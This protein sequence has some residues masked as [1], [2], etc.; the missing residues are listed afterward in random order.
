MQPQRLVSVVFSKDRPLQLDGTLRSLLAHV[1]E[2][3]HCIKVLYTTSSPEQTAL[4]AEVM[5]DFP[6]V[7]FVRESSFK[8]DLLNAL[9]GFAYVL[10]LV[11]D[12]IFVRDFSLSEV[13]S[14]LQRVP[15]A[16]GVSLRLGTNTNYC[17]SLNKPQ[18]IPQL[19]PVAGEFC[20][21][22]W[23]AGQCDFNYPLEVSSSVYDLKLI[24]PVLEQIE[25]KNPN[26][27]EARWSEKASLYSATHPLLICP[28]K[29]LTFCAPINKV[30]SVADNR[31]GETHGVSAEELANIY[32][33]GKILDVKAYVEF[34]PNACHQEVE[35]KLVSRPSAARSQSA[36]VAVVI[37]CYNQASYLPEAVESVVRQTFDNWE[38]IIVNDGSPDETSAV[39]RE[40]IAKFSDKR[41]YLVEKKNGGLADARNWGIAASCAEY[42]LPLDSDDKLQ[43]SAI[44]RLVAVLDREQQYAIA[45]PDYKRFGSDEIDVRCISEQDFLN[46]GRPENGLPYSSLYRR[47][48]WERIGGY[49][50]NMTWGYEDWNFWLSAIECGFKAR[51]V[52]EALF[53]YRVKPGSML[54]NALKHDAELKSQLV[55]NHPRLF[56]AASLQWAQQIGGTRGQSLPVP[57]R[58]E[59]VGAPKAT[60]PLVSVIVPTF[61]R[62]DRLQE[63]LKSILAQTMQDFE[64]IVV[65]DC[66]QDVSELVTKLDPKGR[67]HYLVHQQNKGLAGSRNTGLHAARGKYIAYL[68]DDDLFYPE[69]LETL[70]K[71]LE[72]GVAQVAYTDSYRAT[73]EI[74]NGQRVVRAREVVYSVDFNYDNIYLSNFIPVLC[75]MHARACVDRVG[76]FDE[77]LKRTEDWDLWIRMSQA[78]QFM[79]I[80]KVT[81]EFSWRHDGS[82]MTSSTR[83]AFDWAELNIYYKHRERLAAKPSVKLV[84]DRQ[85]QAAANRLKQSFYKALGSGRF[86]HYKVLGAGSVKDCLARLAMLKPKYAD[87][88]A[89]IEEL[90]ALLSLQAQDLLGAVQHLKEALRI[91]PAYPGAQ[92]ILDTIYAEN[93]QLKDET[94]SSSQARAQSEQPLVS[95]VVPLFNALEY[96]KQMLASLFA[97]TDPKLYELILVD[98]A[99]TDGTREYL[100]TLESKACVIRNAE[101]RNFSGACN[102][103]AQQARGK[104]VLFLNSD[105]I[106]RSQW[107][108]P[109]L[110]LVE[111]RPEVAIVGNKHIY[112]ESGKL[113]HA[114]ICFHADY[115]NS[116]YLVGVEPEDPRVNVE[117]EFQAVNGACFLVRSDVFKKLGGFD[118]TYRNGAEDVELC[119]KVRQAGLKVMYTPKSVIFHYGQRSPGRN[120]NDQ[121][122]GQILLERWKDKIIPDQERLLKEDEVILQRSL[123]AA[124]RSGK[125]R[126]AILSTYNQ[127]CGI[128]THSAEVRAGL[129]AAIKNRSEFDDTVYVL[130]EDTPQRLGVDAH[131]VVR[132]WRKF[133][134]DFSRAR[135]TLRD[136]GIAVLHI[137]FQNGLLGRPELLS[138]VQ[139]LVADG[140]KVFITFHSSEKDLQLCA[141]LINSATLSFVHLEQSRMR[142]IAAGANAALIQ[143]VTHGVREQNDINP[144]VAEARKLTN[145][146]EDV[147]VIVS[148]GFL[149][150]HKGVIEIIQALP[151][152][153]QKHHAVFMFLGAGHPDNPRSHEY[154]DRCKQLAQSLGISNRVIF[155][156]GYLPE[157]TV[158]L[159]LSAADVVVMNYTLN[160]N[161]ASG[162]AAFALA[163]QRPLITSGAPAFRP[164]SDCTMQTSDEIGLAE[165]IDF[166]LAN[167]SFGKFLVSQ[168][169]RYRHANSYAALGTQLLNA[170]ESGPAG[171]RAPATATN[172]PRQGVVVGID[173][174]TLTLQQSVERGI[175]H[176]C[177]HHFDAVIKAKPDWK[178]ILF[179]EEGGF[180]DTTREIDKLQRHPNVETRLLKDIRRVKLDLFHIPDP[181]CL[182]EAWDNPFRMVDDTPTSLTFYDLIPLV[183]HHE[184]LDHWRALTK[185]MYQARLKEVRDSD[186]MVL[187][188]S[189]NTKQDLIRH[190]DFKDE[191]IK[192][193]LGG[194]N[195]TSTRTPGADE[196]KKVLSKH[197]I[198]KPF[199]MTVGALDGHKNV[200]TS[201]TAFI[202]AS[203]ECELQLVIC[204]SLADGMKQRLKDA[205]QKQ[206][207]RN[208]I[209]VGFIPREE[210]ECLYASSRGLLYPSLYEGLGL[211]VLEAMACGCP[212]I[213]S[214][215]A[216]LPEVA[217]DA[218]ILVAPRDVQAVRQAML[219]LVRE[220]KLR[221][222]LI[223]KGK[224][225]AAKF[226]WSE[227]ARKTIDAWNQLLGLEL[228][229][230]SKPAA[231]Y[232]E[233]P[234]H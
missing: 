28:Q 65:N 136:L 53:Q 69:H 101:N 13:V 75:V 43:P 142:F 88:A 74:V 93:P 27:F 132:C 12:N 31:A 25:F 98:N 110:E 91:D 150:P 76:P 60:A 129:M 81:C 151:K 4:Y 16:L 174:R 121:R 48:M 166:I 3:E 2:K 197:K 38:C 194:L 124:P 49:N 37:P 216:S 162:A 203:R 215:A 165:S 32:K 14:V 118:E 51:H 154:G 99:S 161:E 229:A 170:Y 103:G 139:Q 96:T 90:S 45:Y 143:V 105:T 125:K 61:N 208:V 159:Y 212:V 85:I 71:V 145:M 67:I 127:A 26:S 172:A 189:E 225:Q 184:H 22:N 120:S 15:T 163:H 233:A 52:E 19:A 201:I 47:S 185:R 182:L 79:H 95:I 108:E 223:E 64:I 86:D 130:A 36:R 213:T 111:A 34:T 183:R 177:A 70:A 196:I 134:D 220:E 221:Q 42:V 23:T 164:L 82:S 126:V 18:A 181:M 230:Q 33:T 84:Q 133:G 9:D 24:R 175:G 20:S 17:Y 160:R 92:A 180:P 148:F 186:A 63:A 128:A 224:K 173:A 137:Q 207:I 153:F 228:N 73:E 107:L 168:A 193:I 56:D 68:D 156:D 222:E 116:H 190:G 1:R 80:P 122:N 62:P 146:P 144:S 234:R 149:E 119:L 7:T 94:T 199:F 227:V 66:G 41:I 140:V 171:V 123:K 169:E 6:Q 72:S 97:N 231:G 106:L 114:G 178:F 188:I 191:K 198:D 112:P 147:K 232:C 179:V 217:G 57:E 138:F 209:F 78:Y 187:S 158:S 219:R 202:E 131:W 155:A 77:Y 58:V 176:Y 214:D 192:V 109:M 46:P 200:E 211:P 135:A 210:L 54:T 100:S 206:G 8:R 44:E 30:Q 141:A 157:Q 11:D 87:F 10:F 195:R 113:H 104:Y 205:L 102:Q 5:R 117:R 167:P 40:L 83:D 55:L 35:L 226:S 21:F 50:T 204:G 59:K 29:S 115:S 152:V 218:A 39:A 89:L